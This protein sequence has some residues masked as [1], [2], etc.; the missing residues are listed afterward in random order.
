MG[1]GT[2][3]KICLYKNYVHTSMGYGLGAEINGWDSLACVIQEVRQSDHD[4]PSGLLNLG[5]SD[6]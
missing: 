1:L 6:Q 2:E 5:I 3:K 4:G